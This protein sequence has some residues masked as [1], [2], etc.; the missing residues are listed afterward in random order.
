MERDY[1]IEIGCEELPVSFIGPAL[2][3]G[4]RL[5]EDSL[6]K[7]R[8][9]FRNIDVYGTPRRLA[10]IVRGLAARQEI[11]SEAVLGPPKSV[12]FDP[13]GKPTK[14]AVGFAKSQ[15]VN[16]EALSVFPSERGEY[17]GFVR[18]EAAL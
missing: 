3:N 9:G 13:E 2:V 12:A 1:L 18:E 15:G 11:R 7:A 5:L 17:V 6:R 16:V 10:F 4:E 8:L 14:A